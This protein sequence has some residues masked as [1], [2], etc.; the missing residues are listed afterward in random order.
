[1]FHGDGI[2]MSQVTLVLIHRSPLCFDFEEGLCAS[3]W[4]LFHVCY[5]CEVQ[6]NIRAEREVKRVCTVLSSL[7]LD[8]MR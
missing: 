5:S 2:F 4:V 8:V 6:T 1:M 7:L 3:I